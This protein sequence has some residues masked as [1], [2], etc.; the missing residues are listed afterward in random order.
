M[1]DE[2][3]KYYGYVLCIM[4]YGHRKKICLILVC[5]FVGNT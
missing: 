1:N 2:P 5:K 4:Y 3:P